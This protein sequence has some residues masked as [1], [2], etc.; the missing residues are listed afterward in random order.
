MHIGFNSFNHKIHKLNTHIDVQGSYI[1]HMWFADGIYCKQ[2][3][4]KPLPTTNGKL[5]QDMGN[6]M[7]RFPCPPHM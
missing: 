4:L 7:A 6:P 2:D 5:S 1:T 3:A